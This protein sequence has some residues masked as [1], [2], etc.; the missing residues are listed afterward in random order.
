MQTL[1]D[2]LISSFPAP[3]FMVPCLAALCALTS[4][5]NADSKTL[6]APWDPLPRTTAHSPAPLQTGRAWTWASEKTPGE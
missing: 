3:G 5:P 6:L 4:L 2:L 1:P